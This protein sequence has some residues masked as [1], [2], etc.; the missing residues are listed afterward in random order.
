MPG[1]NLS[2]LQSYIDANHTI[3]AYHDGTPSNPC[4]HSSIL[5][6]KALAQHLGPDFDLVAN[7]DRFV[8]Q[9]T[10]AK[11]GVKGRD[12]SIIISPPRK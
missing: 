1:T 6:L 3:T 12:M 4:G 8:S 2:T 9:L 11:C 5:D 7:H 10:C